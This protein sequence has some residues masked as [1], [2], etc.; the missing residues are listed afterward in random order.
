[1]TT[2][3]GQKA[4]ESLELQFWK[5]MCK[6]YILQFSRSVVSDSLRPH[7]LQH[8]R[9]PWLSP[10]PGVYPDSCPLSRWCQPTIILCH[11]L[12]LPPSV[13]PSI[14]VFS[15]E[16]PFHIRWPKYW[17]FTFS[18]SPSGE[19]PGLTSFRSLPLEGLNC[20][21]LGPHTSFWKKKRTLLQ[22]CFSL[23]PGKNGM[24]PLTPAQHRLSYPL[25]Y[26]LKL[27]DC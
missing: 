27:G 15:K 11:P 9:P 3:G 26:F 14:R 2:E 4:P 25:L 20:L 21:L 10:T 18:I 17:S 1:M 13:F 12:L 24:P 22:K 6:S 5:L 16:S 8:T 19:H 23:L 7:E